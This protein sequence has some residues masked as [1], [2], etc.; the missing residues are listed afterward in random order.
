MQLKK[1][2]YCV[3][4]TWD[5]VEYAKKKVDL[6]IQALI[7]DKRGLIVD[8]VYYNNLSAMGG[9]V[10]HSGDELSGAKSEYDEVIW[11]S[12][13]HL[14]DQVKL[15]IFVIAAHHG[16]HLQDATNGRILVA[17]EYV[18]NTVLSIPLES[19]KADVDVVA[20]MFCD[21]DGNWSFSEVDEVAEFGSHFLD[22]IEPTIGDI[23]RKVIPK[24]PKSQL[25]SFQM[26][27]GAVI[28]V[29]ADRMKRL[30]LAVRGK[31]KGRVKIDLD[32]SAVFKSRSGKTLGCVYF[33]NPVM[34]GVTHSGD[35]AKHEDL[36]IDLMQ[37][38]P[39]IAQIFFVVTI[40]AKGEESGTF[41]DMRS[42]TCLVTDQRCAEVASF[43]MSTE[44]QMSGLIVCRLFQGG[45]QGWSFEALQKF[46]AARK[47]NEAVATIDEL[48][49]TKPARS[50]QRR[51]S[52]KKR[53]ETQ[54]N[55]PSQAAV[56]RTTEPDAEG[57]QPVTD[58]A[59]S[60][61][62]RRA[63]LRFGADA[64]S[65]AAGNPV[66][67]EEP[68]AGELN[69]ELLDV[70]RR[71]EGNEVDKDLLKIAKCDFSGDVSDATDASDVE[72]N[73]CQASKKGRRSSESS[74]T[75][76][77]GNLLELPSSDLITDAEKH[78]AFAPVDPVR[79]TP[80]QLTD[81]V[82]I[83]AEPDD[84]LSSRKPCCGEN[85]RFMSC[86]L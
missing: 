73:G 22:I 31:V 13:T 12:L 82:P 47:W 27:K 2:R 67:P 29:G 28:E 20:T 23:I 84:L 10:Q 79:L 60:Q 41:A 66:T 42:T 78:P 1:K 26:E 5:L 37:V 52:K 6:D 81:S 71:R 8:A 39:R 76:D 86:W 46:C 17:E 3:A 75:R 40:Y 4:I 44:E 74:S 49:K 62:P 11:T 25:V 59:T 57:A 33:D 77:R 34:H 72:E 85:T 65:E 24:A 30:N 7:V 58:G 63:T 18:G 48:F 56:L 64:T 51:P 32:I 9:A 45:P 83:P 69:A 16:G 55:S 70:H 68:Q 21:Q 80:S 35:S 15:I 38:P 50:E 19:T 61:K 43:E 36:T 54:Q 14:P 53:E